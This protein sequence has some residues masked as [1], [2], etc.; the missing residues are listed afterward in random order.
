VRHLK[1]EEL[2]DIAEG[3]RPESSAPHLGE[4]DSCRAQLHE[5]R[6]M[7]SAA[8]EVDVPEPSPL[9]WD[10]L[11]SRVHDAVAVDADARL[12][13]SRSFASRSFADVAGFRRLF[14]FRGLLDACRG[15]LGARA[16]QASVLAAAVLLI[17]LAASVRAPS[18]P[19][20]PGMAVAEPAPAIELLRDI[21]SDEDVS[22]T[23]VASLTDHV[24]LDT[25]REAGLATRG[26]AEDAITHMSESELRELGRLLKEE[27]AR[28][29]A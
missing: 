12:K 20:P 10:H 23:L 2:V 24:D 9:F 3:T 26:S 27:L 11:S 13:G 19:T 4:C 5:L 7:M 28:P 1:D 6:A 18:P 21:S 17:A 15:R 16:F 29:G 8:R 14:G 22:L 25:V